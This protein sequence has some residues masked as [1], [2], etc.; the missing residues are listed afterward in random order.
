M[1]MRKSQEQAGLFATAHGLPEGFKYQT[2]ILSSEDERLLLDQMRQLPFKEFQFQGFVGKRR[3]VSYGWRYDFNER[4]LRQ[5]E[6]IPAFL[7]PVR[8]AAAGFAG[9]AP[10]QLAQV[11]L[12]EYDAGSSIGW[13]RDKKMFDDVIGIS[14]LSACRF[15]FRRKVGSTWERASLIAE[16]RSA[17][18][19]RGP[20]RTEWEHSIP[21]VDALR[22]SITFRTLRQGR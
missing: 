5:A 22:Y 3:V 10:E 20:S 6:D 18:L 21:A 2:G 14:L 9:I 19:L 7:L 13:H 15:R 11:L 17:Y 16:P 12:T 8:E 1:V 4:M